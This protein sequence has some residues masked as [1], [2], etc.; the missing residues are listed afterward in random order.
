MKPL[1]VTRPGATEDE[2]QATFV[3][4]CEI[5]LLPEVQWTAFP[6]DGLRTAA[7]AARLKRLGWKAGWP[8]WQAVHKGLYHGLEFKRPGR[9]LTISRLLLGRDGKWRERIGQ[10]PRVRM[11]ESAGAKGRIAVVCS[12][13]DAIRWVN[14]WRML[15]PGAD[16]PK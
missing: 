14:D 7:G 8:D 11:L 10:G 15:R 9:E 13:D 3:R 12:V 5:W 4:W 16:L 1:V 6:S 2:I